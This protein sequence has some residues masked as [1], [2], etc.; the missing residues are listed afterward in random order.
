MKGRVASGVAAVLMVACG[1][2]DGGPSAGPTPCPLPAEGGDARLLPKELRLTEYGVLAE[3]K[4]NEGFLSARIVSETKIVEL[5]PPIARSLV[6]N[7]F[8]I[9]SGDNEGF[10]AEIFFKRTKIETGSIYMRESATCTD[11]V[12]L[13]LTIGLA[14]SKG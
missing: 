13:T 12:T 9:L 14:R 7:G 1:G 5:Y 2:S 11:Q 8:E 4:V 6:A 3:T 10:E